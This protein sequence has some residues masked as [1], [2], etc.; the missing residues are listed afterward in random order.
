MLCLTGVHL[1]EIINTFMAGFALECELSA[2][3][4]QFLCV[5]DLPATDF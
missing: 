1:R 2:A 4:L 3:Q 5:L